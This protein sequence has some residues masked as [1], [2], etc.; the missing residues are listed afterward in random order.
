MS[1]RL[2]LTRNGGP[3]EPL[4]KNIAHRPNQAPVSSAATRRASPGI[5]DA[6]L[7]SDED[8]P[9]LPV[10]S[11]PRIGFITN[12]KSNEDQFS[13][14]EPRGA[15]RRSVRMSGSGGSSS[16]GI[17]PKRTRNDSRIDVDD[18][19]FDFLASSQSTKRVKKGNC[20]GGRNGNI[21]TSATGVGLRG[22]GKTGASSTKRGSVSSSPNKDSTTF[23][24]L[25]TESEFSPSPPKPQFKSLDLN[26]IDEPGPSSKKR[27]PEF[28]KPKDI[29]VDE[30]HIEPSGLTQRT[31]IRRS[32]RARGEPADD[33]PWRVVGRLADD[34]DELRELSLKVAPLLKDLQG[35]S[36]STISSSALSGNQSFSIISDNS[37]LS[38]PPDSPLFED[39]Q[40]LALDVI[41][42][43]PPQYKDVRCPMCREVVDED[44]LQNFSNGR[45]MNVRQQTN[46]CRKHKMVSAR[47]EWASKGYPE[48]S[49]E[50]LPQRFD[51]FFPRLK[52]VISGET[53]SYYR[54][55]LELRME[56]GKNRTLQQSMLTKGFASLTP[57][58]YGPRG[59]QTMMDAI[60]SRFSSDIRQLAASDKVIASG[61]V[62]GYIQ[63]VLCP[64]LAVCLVKE[65]MAVEDDETA[66]TILSDSVDLGDLLNE[67]DERGG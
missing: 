19:E 31:G 9:A 52:D 49:W 20:Y 51:Q 59:A 48:I 1:R 38:S 35:P 28:K 46:F 27:A 5:N 43:E 26:D 56:T 3:S 60:M 14:P 65:D 30:R 47:A 6:P 36:P 18:E 11:D 62:T 21:H 67:E 15:S 10:S 34:N 37:S 44:F 7:S 29:L 23:R 42:P 32:G 39:N 24:V 64:E 16:Q 58:Y 8:E 54:T 61:G 4:H 45:R 13:K 57:G 63:A 55:A 40:A 41:S 12:P 53:Q 33:K 66:R 25:P 2:G 50:E 17:S 22:K